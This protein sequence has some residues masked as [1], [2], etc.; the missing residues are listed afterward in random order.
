MNEENFSLQSTLEANFLNIELPENPQIDKIV[1]KVLKEDKPDFL[2]AYRDININGRITL[3]YKLINTVALA[4]SDRNLTKDQF[5]KLYMSLLNPF[6]KGKDWFLD[7]HNFCIDEKYIFLD[8]QTMKASYIYVP[9]MSYR[10]KDEDIIYFLKKIFNEITIM[11]EPEFQVRM[12]QYFMSDH[13]NFTD[14]Y[15]ILKKELKMEVYMP[16]EQR[17]TEPPKKSSEEP[18]IKE[19][20]IQQEVPAKKEVKQEEKMAEN[21]AF[22]IF[23]T[24]KKK[25]TSTDSALNALFGGKGKKEEKAEHS[26]KKKN[27]AFSLFGKK[28]IKTGEAEKESINNLNKINTA[29]SIQNDLFISGQTYTE[30]DYSDA[31]ETADEYADQSG[32]AYLQL[33]HSEI[34]GAIERI[35]LNF[36]G[37]YI[38]IGRISSDVVKPDVAFSKE[39]TRIGRKHARIERTKEGYCIIDLGSANHTLLNDKTLIPNQPY[40]LMNDAIVTFTTSKPVKYRVVIP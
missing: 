17:S 18:K 10:N 31:T 33:V 38:I 9:E 5:I 23:D 24:G 30:D 3:K 32:I 16:A 37:S 7:Y 29:E 36:S 13:V 6:I 34:P 27:A 19:K 22:D 15:Q 11:N 14:L 8:K 20:Q 35:N 25:T 2:I 21:L 1:D 12:Y 40:P 4:Y 26:E 28:K 39:F